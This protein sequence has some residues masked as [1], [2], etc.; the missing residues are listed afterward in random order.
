MVADAVAGCPHVWFS[1][2]PYAV[3]P[4]HPAYALKRSLLPKAEHSHYFALQGGDLDRFADYT[5]KLLKA[6]LRPLGTCRHPG[7]PPRADR[8]CIKVLNAPWMLEWFEANTDALILTV[9][10]HP[11]AQALSVLRQGWAFPAEAYARRPGDLEAHFSP[12]QIDALRG[13]LRQDD[14]WAA[15]ILDWVVTSHPLRRMGGADV[16]RWTYEDIVADPDRF[17]GEVLV[18][19]FALPLPDRVRHT[20]H[21]PSNSSRMSESATRAAILG[22]DLDRILNG[23]SDRLDDRMRDEGQRILDLF[24]IS[25]YSFAPP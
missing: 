16:L 15:A 22:R 11:A 24:E 10:R 20:F 3:L 13:V 19:A 23:W 5:S 12:P 14:P 1:N 9:I 21:R 7:F 2:E 6:E 17:A 4:A 25:G 8:T 18:R